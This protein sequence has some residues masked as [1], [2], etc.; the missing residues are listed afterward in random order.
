MGFVGMVIS[1]PLMAYFRLGRRAI[2]TGGIIAMTIILFIIGFLSILISNNG[3]VWAMATMMDVWT[4]MYQMTVGP[5]CFVIIAEISATRLRTKTIAIGTAVQAAASII[6]TVAV[7]YMLNSN[8]GNCGG[9][10]LST[11][12]H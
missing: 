8:E 5:I 10:W 7:P 1:W 12:R 4:S 11:R 9:G 3:A 6:F 2:Y